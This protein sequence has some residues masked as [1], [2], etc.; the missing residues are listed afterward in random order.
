MNASPR[1]IAIT[2][3]GA[4]CGAGLTVEAIWDAIQG[5][6]SAVA[7]IRLWD[8]AAWP[9]RVAAQVSGV[10]ARTLVEDRKLQKIISRTDLFGL[11]AASTA[12]QRSG[13]PTYRDS[14]DAAAVVR[15]NDQSGSSPAPEEALTAATTTSSRCS[16]RREATLR[17]S[18]AN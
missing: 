8:A 15:F 9:V 4:V 7:P 12:I 5:G 2:G 10:D 16:L 14:L 18:D 13:L 17:P 1:K 11:Y 6:H 3:L